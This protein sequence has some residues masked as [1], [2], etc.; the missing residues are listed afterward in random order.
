LIKISLLNRLQFDTLDARGTE[1][2]A[3][4]FGGQP[5]RCF[6]CGKGCHADWAAGA[7]RIIKDKMA[8]KCDNSAGLGEGRHA[9]ADG[10]ADWKLF[11]VLNDRENLSTAK[12]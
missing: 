3:A 2:I 6:P 7:A 11:E 4:E 1:D 12:R 8:I 5:F 9:A 10:N